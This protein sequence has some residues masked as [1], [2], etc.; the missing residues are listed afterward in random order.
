MPVV[1]STRTTEAVE[2]LVGPSAIAAPDI[3][4]PMDANASVLHITDGD[5]VILQIDS[6]KEH[7]RLIGIDTPESKKPNTPI[8]CFAK[9]ASAALESLIPV[10]TEIRVERDVEERDR[11]GRLLGYLFRASDGLFVNYEMARTGM[12][13]P[14]T[15]PPNVANADRFVEAGSAAQDNHI[16][17][18]SACASGHEPLAG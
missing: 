9:Q 16:G 5:T 11:Y 15:F 13:V 10:G 17:L 6:T 8:E 4:G 3:R 1:V 18:W 2:V 14:L 7:V 12:A